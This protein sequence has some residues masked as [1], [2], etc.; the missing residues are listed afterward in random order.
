MQNLIL[1]APEK[2]SA[3]AAVDH[4]SNRLIS[5][6]ANELRFKGP[7]NDYVTVSLK[8][9][10]PT[11]KKIAFKLKTTAQRRYTVKPNR[12]VLDPKQSISVNGKFI[13]TYLFKIRGFINLK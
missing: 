11:D 2:E 12:G 10:N 5:D 4:T 1:R 8:I 6:P 9:E 3:G 7:F 13:I